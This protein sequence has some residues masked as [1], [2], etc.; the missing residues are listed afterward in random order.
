MKKEKKFKLRLKT[1]FTGFL[2]AFCFLLSACGVT[3]DNT[4]QEAKD[5]KTVK[6]TQVRSTTIILEYANKKF[7]VDPMLAEKGTM[8]SFGEYPRGDKNPLSDLT[9]DLETILDVDAVL[10]THLH[11]DHFDT[12]AVELIS[13]DMPIYV[14]NEAD[15]QQVQ[16]YGFKD[17]IALD[18]N[19]KV[20]DISLIK[21]E[22]QHGETP[23]IATAIGDSA[24]YILKADNEKTVYIT[25]DTVW[26]DGIEKTLNEYKPDIVIAYAGANTLHS[27]NDLILEGGIDLTDFNGDL[28]LIM[29]ENDILEIHQ[30]LPTARIISTHMESLNHWILS[31]EELRVFSEK[32]KFSDVL[33]IPID[34]ETL[35]Y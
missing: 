12:K 30:T 19:T 20:G 14:Q 15:Q 4:G 1:G 25:G 33:D 34:G 18:N 17:V 3:E 29:D 10:V 7:L 2:L 31:R 26:Y 11:S 32:N 35:K 16:S 27:D 24:G 5:E 8:N 23:E 6:V 13:K 21:T 28:R 9:M 22:C